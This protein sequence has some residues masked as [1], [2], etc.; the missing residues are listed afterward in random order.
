MAHPTPKREAE[1][2]RRNRDARFDVLDWPTED[3]EVPPLPQ[4]LD[5]EGEPLAWHPRTVDEWEAIWRGPMRS[6]FVPSDIFPLQQLMLDVDA[7]NRGER[8]S[9]EFKREIRMQRQ[10]FGLSPAARRKQRVEVRPP[11]VGDDK[12]KRAGG[13]RRRDPRLAS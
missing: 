12:A 3:V 5:D 10:E 9:I 8:T 13:G 1:R 6:E 2:V 11:K 4:L 7:L